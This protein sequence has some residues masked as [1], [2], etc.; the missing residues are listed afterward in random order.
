M[1]RM[2]MAQRGLMKLITG[3]LGKAD[4]AE[5]T[6]EVE[7]QEA[8]FEQTIIRLQQLVEERSFVEVRFPDRAQNTYQSLI[9][10]VD[11]QERVVV[12]DELFP[13]HGA[14]FIS[15][16]DEVEITSVRR[17]IPVRFNTWVKSI[18]LD[19]SDG[20]PAYRL[21]LPDVVE[22]DQRRKHFR[23]S[24]DP[25]AGVRLR[26]RTPEGD[27]LLCTVQDLSHNGIG[28]TCQG[29][30][31]DNLRE[32]NL[33]RGSVLNIPGVADITCD[34]EVRSFEFRRQPYRH[35]MIGARLDGLSTSAEKQLEQ[36]LVLIQRQQRRDTSRS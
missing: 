19:E 8:G 28:F 30:L 25:D 18:S 3:L 4:S 6:T 7:L 15:P 22:A 1:R 16:G 35:M 10:K 2:G 14:F 26:I 32:N 31:T 34:V 20:F 27:K 13:A 36:F 24:V 17:G 23:V 29:N 11:P 12:I 33:L 9:L 21:A 5:E